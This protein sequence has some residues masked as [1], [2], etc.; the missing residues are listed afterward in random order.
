VGL[1][2]TLSYPFLVR[3]RFVLMEWQLWAE[4]ETQ[5]EI[6]GRGQSSYSILLV[7]GAI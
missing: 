2:H 3:R 6:R 7:S 5:G 1:L 4:N